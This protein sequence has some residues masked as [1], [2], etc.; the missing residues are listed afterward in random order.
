MFLPGF[1]HFVTIILAWISTIVQQLF[2]HGF[3]KKFQHLFLHGFKKKIPT[4][5]L[6]WIS[7]IEQQL[8]LHG[9]QNCLTF[10]L[11]S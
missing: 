4:F 10:L 9:F 6:A 5:I 3:K 2:L 11:H 8:F 1:Q 7:T